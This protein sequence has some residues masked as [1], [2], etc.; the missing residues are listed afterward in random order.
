MSTL[1]IV[2]GGKK[3]TL[4]EVVA[5]RLRGQL[6]ERNIKR[7]DL[8]EL[9]GWGRATVYRRLS[10]KTP[11]NTDEMETLERLFGIDPAQLLTGRRTPQPFGPDD[12]GS[13]LRESNPGPSHYLRKEMASIHPL[14][15]NR[16]LRPTG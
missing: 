6:A 5:G 2:E 3:P 7:K 12:G 4:T 15:S 10:G 16:D 1:H 8:V 9:T 14:L 13:R 11:M